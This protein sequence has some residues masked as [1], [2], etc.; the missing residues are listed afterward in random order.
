VES[1]HRAE[2]RAASEVDAIDAYDAVIVGG[3]L[4]RGS[5]HSAARRFVQHHADQLR[6]LPVFFFSSGPLD[7][8]AMRVT[9][10][11]TRDV[12]RLMG[13]VSARAHV[14]FGGRLSRDTQGILAQELVRA[15]RAGDWRDIV[16]IDSWTR[17]VASVLDTLPLAA[18]ASARWQKRHRARQTAATLTFFIG[19]TAAFGGLELII[20]QRGAAWLP[21]LSLLAGTPFSSFLVP[22]LLLL[23]IVGVA[24]LVATTLM[25][26][27][28]LVEHWAVVSAGSLLVGYIAIEMIVTSTVHWLYLVYLAIGLATVAT[29]LWLRFEPLRSGHRRSRGSARLARTV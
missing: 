14:T 2:A 3:A 25:V 24:N 13:L 29:G 7:D 6:T 28:H 1:G 15:G 17:W 4:Y 9:I 26:R 18:P 21:D 10:P 19:A 5:W 22:G 16:H 12:E 11:P 23:G 20:W 8:S 27:R